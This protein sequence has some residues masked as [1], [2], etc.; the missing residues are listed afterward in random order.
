[1]RCVKGVWIKISEHFG[2]K[3]LL[4]VFS[5]RRGI[6][7]WVADEVARKLNNEG[8]MAVAEYLSLISVWF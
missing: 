7:C 5:G 6:H 3:H 4:W 1:M 2:F 8:R